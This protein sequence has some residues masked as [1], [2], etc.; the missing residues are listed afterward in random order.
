VR[1]YCLALLFL[2]GLVIGAPAEAHPPYG[3]VVDP[4]GNAYFSD[5]ETVWRLDPGGRLSV[6]RPPVAGTHVHELAL[7]PGG[8][9]EGDENRYDPATQR[10]FSGLWRRT[11]G[12]KEQAIVPMTE[13][14]PPGMGVLQDAAG[15]RYS[16]QWRSNEDKR[17]VLLRRRPDGTVDSVF[18]EARGVAVPPQPSVAGVGGMALG[19]GGV[20]FFADWDVLRRL[21]ADGSVATLF[22]GGAGASLRGLFSASAGR[23]LAA[24]TTG[25]RVLAVATDGTVS[26]LYREEGGW[27]PTAVALAGER[28]LVLEANADP[29]E[30]DDRVRVIEVK[31][32]RAEVV[33]QPARPKP[34]RNEAPEAGS[35]SSG[36]FKRIAV[37]VAVSVA[38][39]GVW[40]Q[41][42]RAA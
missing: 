40:R 25:K 8:A 36:L 27:L 33:A 28:L 3:L 34:A 5:L 4:A 16:T 21:A 14:P 23:V 39:F 32:G 11:P 15:N 42:R 17:L 18:D 7:A 12:G 38:L 35:E 2:L 19:T 26:T 20:L 29:Y 22:V 6:F 31:D 41:F 37:G 9:I 10:H 1:R 24:D 13:R 30:Y